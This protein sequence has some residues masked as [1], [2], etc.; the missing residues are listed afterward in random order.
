MGVNM[1]EK[2]YLEPSKNLSEAV[3]AGNLIYTAGIVAIDGNG[4]VIGTDAKQQTAA[5]LQIGKKM[6]E[7]LG[8]KV[9]DVIKCTVYL[10]DIRNF[11]LFNEAYVQ[12]FT[13]N[14]CTGKMPARA[15]MEVAKLVKSEWL[16]E[17]EMIAVI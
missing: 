3:K 4:N 5:I 13:E 6:L 10:T 1:T 14:G 11:A 9:S 2:K 17:I 8:A 16:V 12:F 15:T 7:E